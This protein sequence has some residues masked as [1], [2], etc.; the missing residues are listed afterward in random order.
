MRIEE[1]ARAMD[2]TPLMQG[3]EA[4]HQLYEQA[5]KRLAI[6]REEHQQACDKKERAQHEVVMLEGAL[7]AITADETVVA[8]EEPPDTEWVKT[9]RVGRDNY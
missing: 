6:A 9:A 3:K 1:A 2:N 7:K 4:L 8:M 5:Q